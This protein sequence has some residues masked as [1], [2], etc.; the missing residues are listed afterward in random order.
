MR[1]LFEL[2]RQPEISRAEIECVFSSLKIEIQ[3]KKQ[4]NS[5]FFVQTTENINTPDLMNRL[6]GTIK[7]AQEVCS[8]NNRIEDIAAY[9]EQVKS[10]GKIEF[11][12]HGPDGKS[13]ALEVKKYLKTQ[14]RSVRYIEP[15]NTATILHNNLVEQKTDLTLWKH[16]LFATQAIQPIEEWG[17]RDFERPGRDSKSGM[18]PPK[19]ARILLNLSQIDTTNKATLLDPFCGSG[20]ILC[21]AYLLKVPHILGSDASQKAVNDSKKN[22][23]W[24][25]NLNPTERK[26]STVKI[27]VSD[28]TR[29]AN[30][31]EKESLDAIVSEPYLGKPLTGRETK[32]TL[33]QQAKEL[34]SLYVQSFQSF[35]KILKKGG[36]V[37]F[38]IPKFLVQ[39]EWVSINCI[40]EIKKLGFSVEPLTSSKDSLFYHRPT[41][42]VGRE[43]W[44]FKKK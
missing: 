10:V 26:T 13:I 2:G 4:E 28:A 20:T 25:Q 43:I 21:E 16:T 6:G 3:E 39:K 18:I 7:I 1:Y 35:S 30:T 19:L 8:L 11:S 33:L 32:F 5:L 44:K 31:V 41:Q 27:F 38:I 23:E 34:H 14:G 17:E 36:S 9:L 42:F 40:D 37:V 22:I 24:I 15:K 12:L 29:V